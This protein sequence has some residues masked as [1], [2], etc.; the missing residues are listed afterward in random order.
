M[1]HCLFISL[2][3]F[4]IIKA[5]AQNTTFHESIIHEVD[6]GS[7]SSALY[8][9]NSYLYRH[10]NDF[11][12]YLLR[13]RVYEY[14]KETDKALTDYNI[15][16]EFHP[17]DTEARFSRAT[18]RYRTGSLFPAI[19]DFTYIIQHPAKSTTTIVYFE[20]AQNSYSH[21]KIF[22]TQGGIK[23]RAYYF[24]G[25]CYLKASDFAAAASYIDTALH[26]SPDNPDY[27]ISRAL[28]L[29]KMGLYEAAIFDYKKALQI[30]PGHTLA[31]YNLTLLL[32]NHAYELNIL[33]SLN[34]MIEGGTILPYPFAERGFRNFEAGNYKE[35][36]VD[37]N[38]AIQLAPE[39]I[40][41]YMDRA[42]TFIKLEEYEQAEEDLQFILEK[43][44]SNE[45]VY[46]NLAVIAHKKSQFE[47]AVKLLDLAVFYYPEYQKAYVN[48]AI[49][50]YSLKDYTSACLNLE[51]AIALGYLAAPK[52][53]NSFCGH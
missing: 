13:A 29:E 32:A 34:S 22:T 24:L 17:E 9:L 28:S 51:K 36:L 20:K 27:L 18:L 3:L 31:R 49:A 43:E 45:E 2:I 53:L 23:S 15:Y 30:S 44:P 8:K 10:P 38:Y 48:R 33:D 12:S 26:H 4:I 41:Y 6:S 11:Y 39:S 46:L 16:L 5:D 25:L 7:Y 19:E 42:R 47:E 50:Y 35:A 52:M 14:L 37:F 40:E 21:N 1:R